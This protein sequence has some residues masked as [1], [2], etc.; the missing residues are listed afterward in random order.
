MQALRFHR[1]GGP[2]VLVVDQVAR[3]EPGPGEVRVA[4]VAAALNRLD[5]WVRRGLPMRMEMPHIGG[6]DFS[7][8]VEAL[9]PGCRRW[10]VGDAVVGYPRIPRPDAVPGRIPFALLGEE[11]NGAFCEAL[12]LPEDNLVAKPEAL[13]FV[14]AA[15]MPVAFVTAWTMLVLRAGLRAGETLLVQ[16]AGSG[17]GTAAVRIGRHLGARVIACT[18]AG[19]LDAVRGLGADAVIDDRSERV[20]LRV[21]ELTGQHGA[22]VIFEH[23]GAATWPDSIASA[24]PGGRI[25]TCGATTG[26]HGDLDLRLV[27]G[28]ELRIEGV[29]LGPREAL[30]TVLGLAAAGAFAPVIDRVW[31]LARGRE[32]H[33]ALERGGVLGKLV[34]EIDAAMSRR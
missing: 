15:A 14:E 32:A 17:V 12:V 33:E 6:A 30:E 7:G 5:C 31:P 13:S 4:V 24:A 10:S 29:T 2:E 26:A 11:R 28:R 18:S 16:G 22:H 19:K 9:G 34:L 21:R 23:V 20:A 27:F 3:P 25:V 1:R 8:V